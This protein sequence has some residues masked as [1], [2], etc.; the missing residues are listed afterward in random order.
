MAAVKP[1]EV[2]LMGAF[3]RRSYLPMRLPHVAAASQP[4]VRAQ[5][6]PEPLGPSQVSAGRQ[7]MQEGAGGKGCPHMRRRDASGT[8]VQGRLN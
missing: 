2:H 3:F 5:R 8:A 6:D 1:C 4:A 7:R